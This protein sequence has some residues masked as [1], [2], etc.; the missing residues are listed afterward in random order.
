M[1]I[2]SRVLSLMLPLTSIISSIVLSIIGAAIFTIAFGISVGGLV[3]FLI[4]TVKKVD[5]SQFFVGKII[6]SGALIVGIILSW[7]VFFVWLVDDTRHV[8]VLPIA[9]LI[10]EL[11]FA[12]TRKA[13]FQQKICLF[14][15]SL[16]YVYFGAVLDLLFL[17]SSAA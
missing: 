1:K 16:T 2:K 5:I 3:P 17:F 4:I 15:S 9:A 7:S 10:A 13:D 11:F 8:L 14:L 12:A 6:L